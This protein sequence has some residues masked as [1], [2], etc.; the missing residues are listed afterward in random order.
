[1]TQRLR[2]PCCGL[3]R[4]AGSARVRDPILIGRLWRYKSERV[5]VDFHIRYRRLNLWH[6]AGNAV[7]S[8][9]SILMVR[10]FF[11]CR[12]ARAIG[13]QR[14]VAV[15]TYHFGGFSQLSVIIGAVCIVATEARHAAPIHHALNEIIALHPIFMSG[16][17]GEMC[18]GGRAERVVF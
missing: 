15:Q 16:T 17:F 7:A 12:R 8:G 5:G 10:V 11:E 1:M 13:R 9:A 3:I 2:C 6:V 14:T 18:E 4:V